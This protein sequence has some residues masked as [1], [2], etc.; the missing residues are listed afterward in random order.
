MWVSL[1]A[2]NHT[3]VPFVIFTPTAI[4]RY[5]PSNFYACPAFARHLTRHKLETADCRGGETGRETIV[6]IYLFSRTNNPI[7]TRSTVCMH[8]ARPG[9]VAART[10]APNDFIVQRAIVNS[11]PLSRAGTYDGSTRSVR[12]VLE[13]ELIRI[14]LICAFIWIPW[15]WAGANAS[16]HHIMRSRLEFRAARNTSLY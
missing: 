16:E 6:R 10:M 5:F 9:L 7:L 1:T 15:R 14:G 2:G 4:S 12:C 3:S 13:F 11:R 8:I